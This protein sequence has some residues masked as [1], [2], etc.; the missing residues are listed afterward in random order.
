LRTKVQI[1]QYSLPMN[2]NQIAVLATRQ[3]ILDPHSGVGVLGN[4]DQT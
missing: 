4:E 2:L 1:G 3:S